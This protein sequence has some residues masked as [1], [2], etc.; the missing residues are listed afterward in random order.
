M[1]MRA[2]MSQATLAVTLRVCRWLLLGCCA[3]SPK[4]HAYVDVTK[5]GVVGVVL[6]L[7]ERGPSAVLAGAFPSPKSLQFQADQHF[8]LDL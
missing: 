6:G 1:G 4:C 2:M 8:G 5:S 7:G 3:F